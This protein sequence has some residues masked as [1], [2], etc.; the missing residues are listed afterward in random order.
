[1]DGKKLT[2]LVLDALD[3]DAVSELYGKQRLIYEDLDQAAAIFA[4]ETGVLHAEHIITTVLGQQEYD[5]P[6]DYI[7]PYLQTSRGRFFAKY[8][9]GSNYTWPLLSTYEKIFKSNLIESKEWPGR[10]AIHDKLTKEDLIQGSADAD[11]AAAGGECTLRDDSMLFLTT[12]RV[13]PRDTIH[14]TSDGSD[15]YVLSVTDPTHLKTALFGGTVN[16]WTNG[17]NYIIQP[18]A[19]RQVI[20]DAPSETTGHAMTMP[21]VCMPSP[22]FSDYGFWRINPRSCRAIAAGAAALFKIPKREFT[23]SGQIGGLFAAEIIRV[24]REIAQERLQ[25]GNYRERG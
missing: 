10:F 13:Y 2:V 19:E 3:E 8:Y 11:G 5:L 25:Q 20:L 18:A 16:A 9:D 6:P 24:K 12:N 7:R 15:G 17:D 22:V 14:N 23:E 4:R 21:Y 1:M